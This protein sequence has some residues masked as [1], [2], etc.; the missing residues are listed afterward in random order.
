MVRR[1]MAGMAPIAALG[2]CVVVVF[3]FASLGL[4]SAEGEIDEAI[5]YA[6]ERHQQYVDELIELVKIPSIS[7][8]PEHEGDMRKAANWV[9]GRCRKAGLENV[10]VLETGAQ[11]IVYCD[12]IHAEGA[13]TVL[14][15]AHYDVQ[16]A[17]PFELWDHEPFEARSR[18]GR[19]EGRG[20]SDDKSG[21]LL[22]I[23]AAEAVL[24]T[25]GGKLPVNVKY[26]LEGQ[27]EI[28]SPNLED[29]LSK[30]ENQNRFAADLCFSA[31]GGQLSE[32][33]PRVITSLRGL[34]AVEVKV[35]TANSDM[36]SGTFGG[37]APNALHVI[38]DMVASLHD[39]DGKVNIPGFYDDVALMT[40]QEKDNTEF[41]DEL[42]EQGMRQDGVRAFPGERGFGS[43]ERTIVRPTLEITGLWG[44]FQG[45]GVKTIVPKEASVKIACRLVANQEAGKIQ[46]LVRDHITKIAPDY[47]ELTFTGG[48]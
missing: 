26:L 46:Q 29:F 4:A 36:H 23:Q 31:D 3:A 17:D 20:A 45:D 16:P 37:A 42:F 40:Q 2:V 18:N 24:Q 28:G 1:G 35:K 48:R 10:E 6:T 22:S 11:P 44:G 43:Y 8:L 41:P 15:Y 47:A 38:A 21:V 32:K 25:S 5:K 30:S 39:A 19:V 14:I 13:P 34:A 33:Q 9:A 7:T 27:E 12:Y